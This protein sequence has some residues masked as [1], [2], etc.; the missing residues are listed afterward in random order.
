M[1]MSTIAR[2]PEKERSRKIL[3]LEIDWAQDFQNVALARVLFTRSTFFEKLSISGHSGRQKLRIRMREAFAGEMVKNTRLRAK[4]NA[5]SDGVHGPEF[6]SKT[7]PSVEQTLF[8]R[9]CRRL[10]HS[11]ECIRPARD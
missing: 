2:D 8:W 6:W 4:Y 7:C 11:E 1:E 3:Q 10:M 9:H 5:P